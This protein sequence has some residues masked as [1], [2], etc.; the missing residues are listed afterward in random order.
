MPRSRKSKRQW[1]QNQVNPF[2]TPAFKTLQSEWASKLKASGFKDAENADSK[3][4]KSWHSFHFRKNYTA[5]EFEAK[6]SYFQRANEI[7]NSRTFDSYLERKIWKQHSE[8][9]SNAKIYDELRDYM[10]K[11]VIPY[12]I[13]SINK[14]D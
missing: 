8:G 13:K 9:D 3:A 1:N 14:N 5:T 6:E 11:T 4:L 2:Q 12:I 7:L 10:I